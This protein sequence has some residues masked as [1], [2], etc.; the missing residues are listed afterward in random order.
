MHHSS[1]GKNGS[2][3][4]IVFGILTLV[5]LL[6]SCKHE[7]M[8]VQPVAPIGATN[9]NPPPDTVGV[10]I[11][12][13]DTVYFEQTVLPMMVSYCATAGCHNAASHQS[14]VRL[15]DYAHIHQY[16]SPGNPSGTSSELIY[17]VNSNMPP[18]NHPQLTSAQV[19]D[20]VTWITQGALNNSCQPTVCDTS[21]VSYSGTIAPLMANMCNGCH[22]HTYPD[23]GL[24]LTSYNVMNIIA[25]DGR[26]AGS[27]Q[28]QNF[29]YSMPPVG[30]GLSPCHIQQVLTWI[31]HGAP[32][33]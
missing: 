31:Q 24:D 23:G 10:V 19:A 22:G 29:Y 20:L 25:L 2:R 13:P 15:Y 33:D 16:V 8:D 11:C 7:P 27:I 6:G 14:G 3:F 21:N 17:A 12:D 26:L 5:L 32:N 4:V 28:H 18:F 1:K 30:S 9:V